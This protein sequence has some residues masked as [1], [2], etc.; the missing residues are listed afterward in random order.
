MRS[1]VLIKNLRANGAGKHYRR[2]FKGRESEVKV[3]L[4]FCLHDIHVD[5]VLSIAL[6]D[7]Y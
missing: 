2:D 1:A 7:C 3:G 5:Q 4:V 6:L